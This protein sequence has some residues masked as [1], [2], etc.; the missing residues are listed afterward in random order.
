MHFLYALNFQLMHQVCRHKNIVFT[1]RHT[2]DWNFRLILLFYVVCLIYFII[3]FKEHMHF[4][5]QSK[6]IIVVEVFSIHEFV[7]NCIITRLQYFANVFFDVH[8]IFPLYQHVV[9][10]I[11]DSMS[12]FT[13][14]LP[15]VND[16]RVD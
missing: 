6:V 10:V 12:V 2:T 15:L 7:I 13:I 16:W 14:Y 11:Y 8:K 1:V 9:V 5:I 4:W 3:F